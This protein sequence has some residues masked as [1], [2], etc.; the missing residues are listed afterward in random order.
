MFTVQTTGDLK[1]VFGVQQT[2]KL[3]PRS[4]FAKHTA[5]CLYRYTLVVF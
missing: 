4:G 1:F 3:N 5:D 2:F